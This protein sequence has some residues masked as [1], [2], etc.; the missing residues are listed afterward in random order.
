VV[1]AALVRL[2][3]T[4]TETPA[5]IRQERP[6]AAAGLAMLALVLQAEVAAAAAIILR[7]EARADHTVE[8]AAVVRAEG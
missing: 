4:A 5:A 7:T 3:R 1:V 8:A 6:L 2:A